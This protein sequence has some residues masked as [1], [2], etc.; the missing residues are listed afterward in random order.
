MLTALVDVSI[1]AA[2]TS[3]LLSFPVKPDSSSSDWIWAPNTS[4][5]VSYG[6]NTKTYW[7]RL[8]LRCRLSHIVLS[9]R[10]RALHT[11]HMEECTYM[12]INMQTIPPPQISLCHTCNI[13]L[14]RDG[15]TGGATPPI[16]FLLGLLCFFLFTPFCSLL[17]SN[18][19][20]RLG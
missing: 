18:S 6:D 13:L 14:S 19:H 7:R 8:P 11:S 16:P 15:R 4:P 20:R 2:A 12:N 3:L 5:G 1:A 10:P 9:R 17:P